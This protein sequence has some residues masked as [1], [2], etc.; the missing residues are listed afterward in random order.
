MLYAIK[1]NC[2]Y[3]KEQVVSFFR[4][5]YAPIRSWS[6]AISATPFLSVGT[7]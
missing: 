5:I 4:V 3:I 1:I 6:D 2:I 7:L